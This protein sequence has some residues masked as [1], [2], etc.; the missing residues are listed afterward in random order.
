MPQSNEYT[1]ISDLHLG[2]NVCRADNILEFLYYLETENLI[3]N[4]DILDNL[5]FRRLNK[6]HWMVIKKLRQ[7]SKH[8]NVVWISGNH[9][10]QSEGV[11]AMIG[12]S[13]VFEY[14]IDDYHDKTIYITHGD[15]FDTIITKRPLLT[16]FADNIYRIIQ[17]FD[18]RIDNNYYY[19]GMI[20]RHSK[21]LT[22]V[23]DN[24]I[25]NAINFASK[26]KYDSIIIGHLHKPAILTT[27]ENN[28][29]Y[30]NSGCWTEKHC[31]YVTIN[32]GFVKLCTF[33]PG[34]KISTKDKNK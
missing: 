17:L 11:A 22:R 21:T 18:K 27:L 2:T 4:G 1:I 30:V 8:T 15:I 26:N 34:I 3:L 10:Y 16:K 23:T 19:S 25:S 14:T 13:F 31:T 5:D 33:I 28:V 9:D 24:T 6:E 32:Q 29:E 20:K 12:A 7:I